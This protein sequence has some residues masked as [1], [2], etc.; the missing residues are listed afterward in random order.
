MKNILTLMSYK[1][2]QSS[3]HNLKNEKIRYIIASHAQSYAYIY[4]MQK[5]QFQFFLYFVPRLLWPVLI[6]K[7]RVYSAGA[8]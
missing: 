7:F 8:N 5:I 1:I 3:K 6:P 4:I 2:N